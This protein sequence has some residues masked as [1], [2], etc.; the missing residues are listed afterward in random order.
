[1]SR[2][3]VHPLPW[4]LAEVGGGEHKRDACATVEQ[5]SRLFAD[6][7]C[8]RARRLRGRR[9]KT[10]PE[11]PKKPLFL[12]AQSCLRMVW[13]RPSLWDLAS[14]HPR[15]RRATP[16]PKSAS[17]DFLVMQSNRTGKIALKPSNRAK[18]IALPLR[19]S[20][21]VAHIGQAGIP[22]GRMGE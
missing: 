7:R 22:S 2:S 20:R 4:P 19:R 12:A 15:P 11:T 9:A 6:D 10:T 5:A 17:G 21:W 13:L 1:M 14:H 18:E 3:P 8:S 16:P